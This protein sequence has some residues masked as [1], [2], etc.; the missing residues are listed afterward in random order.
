MIETHDLR[1]GYGQKPTLDGISLSMQNGQITGLVGANGAGKSTLLKLL[2]GILKPDDGSV[3]VD[4]GST[5]ALSA[6]ALAKKLAYLP[7][8]RPVPEMTVRTLVEMGRFAHDWR[9]MDEVDKALE[10]TG[11]LP[12]ADR[13][14]DTLSGGQR[15]MAYLAMALAQGAPNILLDEP[16]THLDEGA[17][18]D[19]T[20]I[21]RQMKEDGKCVCVVVHELSLLPR[22]CDRAIL[23]S[24]GQIVFDGGADECLTS[25]E[26][27]KAFGVRAV[28]DTGVRFERR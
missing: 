26:L 23:L 21:L 10:K 28:T 11:M 8:N 9:G 7:Q 24:G 22:V 4:G 12:F 6:K 25:P 2:A 14:A 15:Q 1:F 20:D 16:L 5:R 3:R 13:C 27:E 18:L 17:R 19:V